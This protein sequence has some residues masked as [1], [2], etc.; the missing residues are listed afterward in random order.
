VSLLHRKDVM[1]Q[2][3]QATLL[4]LHELLTYGLKGVAAYAHHAEMLGMVGGCLAGAG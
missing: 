2:S 3:G 1:G 4:G